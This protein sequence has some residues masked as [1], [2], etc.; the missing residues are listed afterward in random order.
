MTLPL[1]IRLCRRNRKFQ[2]CKVAKRSPKRGAAALCGERNSS[3]IESGHPADH[4]LLAAVVSADKMVGFRILARSGR[5]LGRVGKDG[6]AHD[7]ASKGNSVARRIALVCGAG[8][9]GGALRRV[10]YLGG[11]A[12]LSLNEDFRMIRSTDVPDGLSDNEACSRKNLLPNY[13]AGG[14]VLCSCFWLRKCLI[15]CQRV[16]GFS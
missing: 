6:F 7:A 11:S 9:I 3:V 5:R 4:V 1:R 13:A 12:Y 15:A 10:V 16:R 8:T 2:K 14:L